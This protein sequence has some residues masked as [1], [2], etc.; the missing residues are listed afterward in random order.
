MMIAVKSTLEWVTTPAIL[1]R[2]ADDMEKDD[3]LAFTSRSYFC[4]Y[5]EVYNMSLIIRKDL[6]GSR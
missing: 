4:E 2:I 1:R 5:S 3:K 6:N